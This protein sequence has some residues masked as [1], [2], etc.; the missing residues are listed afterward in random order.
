MARHFPHRDEGVE[1]GRRTP[2]RTSEDSRCGTI[3]FD[4]FRLL[5]EGFVQLRTIAEINILFLYRRDPSKESHHIGKSNASADLRGKVLDERRVVAVKAV[6]RVE[7]I[8]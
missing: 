5:P 3:G 6:T 7:N 2:A 4:E 8:H 1:A